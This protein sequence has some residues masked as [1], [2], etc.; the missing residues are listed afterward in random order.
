MCISF[1]AW[2]PLNRSFQVLS[3]E[4]VRSNKKRTKRKTWTQIKEIMQLMVGLFRFSSPDRFDF[5]LQF[6]AS[7]GWF[8]AFVVQIKLNNQ[9]DTR[10]YYVGIGGQRMVW[11]LL[12]LLL[13][14]RYILLSRAFVSV[15]CSTSSHFFPL[16]LRFE[17]SSILLLLSSVKFYVVYDYQ[18][19]TVCT[20]VFIS[21]LSSTQA[22][23]CCTLF[24]LSSRWQLQCF[25]HCGTSTSVQIQS[26]M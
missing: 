4:I 24:T 11:Y 20:N 17:D 8:Y 10:K 21:Y 12:F 3:K 16:C 5:Q 6:A 2:S 19:A 23:S 1:S 15:R 13:F 18:R 26:I 25:L 22:Y 9:T 14:F 7:L